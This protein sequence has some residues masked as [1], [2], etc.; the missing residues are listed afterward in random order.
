[1]L[2]TAVGTMIVA[3]LVGS[4]PIAYL[5]ARHAGGIDIRAE[6]EGNVG[7][8]NVFHVVG[9]RWGLA[10]FAGDFLKGSTVAMLFRHSP[11][12]QLAI[13]AVAVLIGHAFPVWLDF[14]GG[15]GLST[16]G[17][18]TAVLMP[19]ATLIGGALAGVVWAASKSFYPTTIVAI[20]TAVVVAP[21]TGVDIAVVVLVVWLFAMAGIKRALDEPR[22]RAVE[23]TTGWD[24]LRG[25]SP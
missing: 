25:M 14:V 13:A 17:G 5:I 10:A 24:R 3:Y 1:M 21:L 8:R 23:A 15:K 12:W 22:M 4:L 18:V 9:S 7:A 2:V 19:W 20:V 11:L 16:A 6:G